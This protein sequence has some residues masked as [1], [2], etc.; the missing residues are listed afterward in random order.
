M[1]LS[2]TRLLPY[3]LTALVALAACGGPAS[4]IA[5]EL[6]AELGRSD[7]RATALSENT[8]AAST[9]RDVEREDAIALG[10][11][12]RH[13]LGLGSPWRLID[14]ALQDDRLAD[15][16]RHQVAWAILARTIT[17]N[18]EERYLGAL[19]YLAVG[20]PASRAGR[21]RAHADL[22]DS[23]VAAAADP[24]IGELTIRLAYAIAGAENK[25]GRQALLVSTHAAALARD[26]VLARR[27]AY[28]LLRAAEAGGVDPVSLVRPWRSERRFLAEQP[29]L[30][31]QSSDAEADAMSAVPQVLAAIRA[32]DAQKGFVGLRPAVARFAM[33]DGETAKSARTNAAE[34]ESLLG[35]AAA[36]RLAELAATHAAPPQPPVLLAIRSYRSRVLAASGTHERS[37]DR[38]RFVARTSNEESLA[39][40]Y[41]LLTAADAGNAAVE[42]AVLTAAVSLRAYAQEEVWFP[43]MQGS[44]AAELKATFGLASVSFDADVPAAWRPF[45]LR[46]LE[47]GLSDLRRV[48]PGLSVAGAGIHFGESVMRDAALALHDPSTRTI[49]LPITSGAGALAHEI[50]HDLDWQ[51]ARSR[52]GRQ[53]GYG[54][55][56]AVREESARTATSL[57]GLTAATLVPPMPENGFSPPHAQRPAEVFARNADWFIAAALAR[58]GRMNGYLSAVQDELLAGY[59]AA[60]PPDPTG[61]GGSALIALLDD[62]TALPDSTRAWFLSRF[63]Q[64]RGRRAFDLVQSVLDAPLPAQHVR[65][66]LPQGLDPLRTLLPRAA[67]PTWAGK[68]S[69]GDREREAFEA[70]VLLA[71]DVRAR[72]VASA[73]AGVGQNSGIATNA[74]RS[75]H[76]FETEVA[77]IRDTLLARLDGQA[78]EQR[79]F[80]REGSAGDC[81]R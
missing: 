19:D 24:R 15:S 4:E 36:A 67:C 2:R 44:T 57:R 11:L 81:V 53:G 26:R 10:Y 5:P 25:A 80:A 45:Y 28:A 60:E 27:D 29:M 58:E 74:P 12:E 42:L 38:E 78:A 22:I 64:G 7:A 72:S 46:T 43:G 50:M 13:R 21:G 54:T 1:L 3:I 14:Y 40:E 73:R 71:A 6:V 62:M 55:D 52:F 65:Q 66:T 32:I 16:V 34:T 35:P 17:A 68:T 39:A 77:H 47:Q 8:E 31:G 70:V 79:P 20:S 9:P 56:R 37:P 30:I 48:F 41:A 69:T 49:Y 63:G 61:A 76:R 23:V 59:V 51:F 33:R 75:N 18:E